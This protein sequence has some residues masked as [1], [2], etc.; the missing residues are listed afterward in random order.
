MFISFCGEGWNFTILGSFSWSNNQ[1]E[2][3]LS[4][5]ND[6]TELQTYIWEPPHMSGSETERENDVYVTLGAKAPSDFREDEGHS[7]D[8]K[9]NMFS[10]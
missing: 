2:N 3:D 10:N 6:L 1:I 8:D 9:K 5:E 4:R 7:Q